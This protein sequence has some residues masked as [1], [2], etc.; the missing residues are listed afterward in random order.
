VAPRRDPVTGEDEPTRE[1]RGAARAGGATSDIPAFVKVRERPLKTHVYGRG[2]TVFLCPTGWGLPGET[3]LNLFRAYGDLVRFFTFDPSGTGESAALRSKE[4]L[5]SRG[6]ANDSSGMLLRLKMRPLALLGHSHGGCAALRVAINHPEL[7]RRLVVVATTPGD[8][9]AD[10]WN[11]RAVLGNDAP[12]EPLTTREQLMAVTRRIMINALAEPDR[13]DQAFAGIEGREWHVAV[14]RFN[15]LAKDGRFL[16]LAGK[17]RHIAAPT[18]IAAGA[19]DPLVGLEAA[20]AMRAEIPKS[21]LVVFE[22]S[23]HFPMLEEPQ[24]FRTVLTEF[25]ERD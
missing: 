10:A 2:G 19:K 16:D 23:G 18:L 3:T 12:R 24:K 22:R 21:E 1:T 9:T 17:M 5:G 13:P 8:G 20:E 6:I 4:D 25:F 14:E 15:A 11:W 7:V